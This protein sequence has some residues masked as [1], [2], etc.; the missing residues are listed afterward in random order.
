MTIIIFVSIVIIGVV[1]YFLF[2]KKDVKYKYIKKIDICQE[3][4]IKINNIC[5][6]ILDASD[7]QTDRFLVPDDRFKNTECREMKGSEKIEH[8]KNSGLIYFLYKC[9]YVKTNEDCEKEDQFS[10]PNPK[11]K[12]TTCTEMTRKEKEDYCLKNNNVFYDNKCVKKKSDDMCPKQRYLKLDPDT[13]NTTCKKMSENEIRKLCEQLNKKYSNKMCVDSVSKEDC[14]NLYD[15][16]EPLFYKIPNSEE[17]QCVDLKFSKKIEICSRLGKKYDGVKC[18]CPKNTRIFNNQCLGGKTEEQCFNEIKFSKPNKASGNTSCI[19]M[20]NKEREKYCSKKNMIYLNNDCKKILTVDDCI[21]ETVNNDI[22]NKIPDELKKNTECRDLTNNEKEKICVEKDR[23]WDGSN[24]LIKLT[25]PLIKIINIDSYNITIEIKVDGEVSISDLSIEQSITDDN[26]ESSDLDTKIGE[27]FIE[28]KDSENRILKVKISKLKQNNNYKLKL[29]VLTNK[30]GL[31]SPFSDIISF[32]TICDSDIYTRKFCRNNFGP[33]NTT[34]SIVINKDP[35]VTKWPF[36]KVPKSTDGKICGCRSLT[37]SESKRF[38]INAYYP[39]FNNTN[40]KVLIKGG[41]CIPAPFAVGPPLKTNLQVLEINQKINSNREIEN[42]LNEE[43]YKDNNLYRIFIK[44]SIPDLSEFEDINDVFPEKYMIYRQNLLSGENYKLI[45][46]LN[47]TDSSEK[48]FSYLDETNLESE[49][50]YKYK[51]V[52][53]NSV[54]IGPYV[55]SIIKTKK[56]R[57]LKSKCQSKLEDPDEELENNKGFKGFEMKLDILNNKCFS[58]PVIQRNIKCE[59]LNSI[60]DSYNNIYNPVTKKCIPLTGELKR[61]GKPNLS[62]LDKTSNSIKLNII[63]PDNYG[64]PALNNYILKW[65]NL[66]TGEKGRLTYGINYDEVNIAGS[67]SESSSVYIKPNPIGLDVGIEIIHNNLKP[68]NT[69]KYSIASVSFNDK[70]WDN[71]EGDKDVEDNRSVGKSGFNIINIT[72]FFSVPIK[73]PNINLLGASKANEV[74]LLIDIFEEGYE[75]G[76]I[77]NSNKAVIKKYKIKRELFSKNQVFFINKDIKLKEFIITLDNL[78]DYNS[79]NDDSKMTYDVAKKEYVFKD[80]SI[81][82]FSNYRYYIYAINNKVNRWS[83]VS[84]YTDI[85]TPELTPFYECENPSNLKTVEEISTKRVNRVIQKLIW[86]DSINPNIERYKKW[87]IFTEYVNYPKYDIVI[88]SRNKTLKFDDIE[89]NNF[90]IRNLETDSDYKIN[91]IVRHK[92]LLKLQNGYKIVIETSNYSNS[93]DENHQ[94]NVVKPLLKNIK[95]VE[96]SDDNDCK[97]NDLYFDDK[98]LTSGK[99][100]EYYLDNS[101]PRKCLSRMDNFVKLTEYCQKENDNKFVFWN[102]TKECKNPKDGNWKKVDVYSKICTRNGLSGD[103]IVCGGGKRIKNKYVYEKPEQDMS[104]KLYYPDLNGKDVDSPANTI[105]YLENGVRVAYE[106]ESCSDGTCE[107]LCKSKYGKLQDVAKVDGVELPLTLPDMNG[108]TYCKRDVKQPVTLNLPSEIC[109]SCGNYNIEKIKRTWKC[110]DGFAGKSEI[111]K[112]NKQVDDNNN[113]NIKNNVEE[114]IINET[115]RI[116]GKW[117][118]CHGLVDT[119]GK[120]V[121]HDE[122]KNVSYCNPPYILQKSEQKDSSGENILIKRHKYFM[123]KTKNCTEMPYCE[124]QKTKDRFPVFTNYCGE[125]TVSTNKVCIGPDGNSTIFD[126]C[127]DY[128]N[129]GDWKLTKTNTLEACIDICEGHA[130]N[131]SL[132]NSNGYD[133]WTSYSDKMDSKTEKEFKTLCKLKSLVQAKY[134]TEGVLG[135]GCG[136]CGADGKK[137]DVYDVCEDGLYGPDEKIKCELASSTKDKYSTRNWS[138][139]KIENVDCEEKGLC[140]KKKI[141]YS[142]I[143][144]KSCPNNRP[145][146]DWKKIGNP[147]DCN[148]YCNGGKQRQIVLCKDDD[149]KVFDN[150]C[151]INK[152]PTTIFDCNTESCSDLCIADGNKWIGSKNKPYLESIYK[153]KCLDVPSIPRVS[154]LDERTCASDMKGCGLKNLIKKSFCI[155]GSGKNEKKC[156]EIIDSD[157]SNRIWV[158]KSNQTNLFY[159]ENKDCFKKKINGSDN[160][161]FENFEECHDKNSKETWDQVSVFRDE[162][163]STEDLNCL[164][165]NEPHCKWEIENEVNYKDCTGT[166]FRDYKCVD[167]EGKMVTSSRCSSFNK[168]PSNIN[169]GLSCSTEAGNWYDDEKPHIKN[170]DPDVVCNQC[171]IERGKLIY[172]SNKCKRSDGIYISNNNCVETLQSV[173]SCPITSSCR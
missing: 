96:F 41:K 139:V 145:K 21:K 126:K 42:V 27:I 24:C 78:T 151:D 168:P 107:T 54:G 2:I 153:T 162:Y 57:I 61:P 92:G 108:I 116:E 70:L 18:N 36:F 110:L 14:K 169:L 170:K 31:K 144:K 83:K 65:E 161:Y 34:S 5:K 9:R 155:D 33:S 158:K 17:T 44:W 163:Y 43:D 12:N 157:T 69:Y 143:Y 90:I 3:N 8:C 148:A 76:T 66:T 154:F 23:I 120:V 129:T 121:P 101:V 63:P 103:Y 105:E 51:I 160:N 16:N 47:I 100:V 59:N 106:F 119:D 56:K 15:E 53:E 50:L 1:I 166:L 30:F 60:V 32:K 85:T 87:D 89:T 38:C 88:N 80:N 172:R 29:K 62:V 46:T 97:K 122:Y 134:Y 117:Y 67:E 109:N 77:D 82:P 28:E 11:Y 4:E 114:G 86:D 132:P 72:T 75:G 94:D 64:L 102:K 140:S 133:K 156:T 20:S 68:A 164:N 111:I 26:S 10:K 159:D 147:S 93:Y 118:K 81:Q 71:Y 55:E 37:K 84:K 104:V 22:F 131:K 152:K 115:D 48:D 45:E 35:E 73:I 167:E 40:R 171:G 49:T 173:R 130:S 138:G 150:N 141:H 58:M 146:C 79:S 128:N 123:Q 19:L 136:N 39:N 74:N 127:G 135:M 124:Y 7:C 125:Q 95:T 113:L 165:N 142:N 13:N 149:L 137:K 99:K 6:R 52:P 91:L 25:K 98:I 112:C